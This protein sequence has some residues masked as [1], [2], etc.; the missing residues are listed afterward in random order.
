MPISLG[1]VLNR[2][3]NFQNREL[4]STTS[5]TPAKLAQNQ[6]LLSVGAT[7]L[8]GLE[9]RT[10]ST[11]SRAEFPTNP[12]SFDNLKYIGNL[13]IG[14]IPLTKNLRLD[15]VEDGK[16]EKYPKS[17]N[18]ASEP[19]VYLVNGIATNDGM[20]AQMG[21]QTAKALGKNITFVNNSTEGVAT[22]LIECLKE[23]V[24]AIP[25]KPAKTLS[26]EIY[27]NLTSTPPKKMELIGYSQGTIMTTHALSLAIT[28]M[29]DNGY[30]DAQIKDLMSQN[31]KVALTGCPVDLNNPAHTICNVP[32]GIPNGETKRLDYY[33]T[34]EDRVLDGKGPN[35]SEDI[36]VET[37][38][39][40]LD[41]P[42]FSIVRHDKDLVATTIHDITLG[43]LKDIGRDPVGLLARLSAQLIED[44]GNSFKDT[45]NPV[46]YHMYDIVYL[47]Y[48]KN[49]ILTD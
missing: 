8:P 6:D 23:L 34:V 32:P 2:I 41:K 4:S 7:F 49:K 30:T 43:D 28:K 17:G 20:R 42:N 3:E 21:E 25:S 13:L 26:N 11:A 45:L 31:V 10:S 18:L 35:F 24:F 9:R 44:L 15:T 12:L 29:K 19:K 46:G 47:D 39:G 38:Q 33:F 40:E 16:I 14:T 48:T 5:V 22:D 1:S 37:G 36:S 27:Q